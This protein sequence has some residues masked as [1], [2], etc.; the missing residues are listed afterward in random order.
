MPRTQHPGTRVRGST[1]K[2]TDPAYTQISAYVRKTTVLATKR[3]LLDEVEER[4]VSELIEEL[5][6]AWLNMKHQN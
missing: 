2:R 1:G 5:L 4:D 6:A 3:A